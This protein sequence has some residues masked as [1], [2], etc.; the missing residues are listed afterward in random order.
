M[1]S[2]RPLLIRRT[3]GPNA[4][5]CDWTQQGQTYFLRISSWMEIYQETWFL[6]TLVYILAYIRKQ[7]WFP[8]TTRVT[9]Q[10]LLH[11]SYSTRVEVIQTRGPNVRTRNSSRDPFLRIYSCMLILYQNTIL[12]FI[13]Q[14][15]TSTSFFT[16][17]RVTS[18][19]CYCCRCHNVKNGKEI[20][21]V[22]ERKSSRMRSRSLR[23]VRKQS[24]GN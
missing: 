14:R 7:D 3:R 20:S 8:C 22:I 18:T 10:K 5:I 24:K 6:Y 17:A 4:S 23:R 13:L 15:V 19:C 12:I 16:F 21:E 9:P 11:K 1:Q 2:P